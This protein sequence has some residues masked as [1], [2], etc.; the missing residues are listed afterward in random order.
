MDKLHWALDSLVLRDDTLFG[1]GWLFHEEKALR[2]LNLEI[3]FAGGD[4]ASRM[5]LEFDKPRDDVAAAYPACA[6]AQKPGYM[7]FGGFKA[8]AERMAGLALVGEWED[9]EAIGVDIPLASVTPIPVKYPRS[10][11]P[12]RAWDLLR[13]GKLRRLYGEYRAFR[14]YTSKDPADSPDSVPTLLR[15]RQNPIVLVVDH[16]LGGGANHYRE[17]WV[18]DKI[19]AGFDVLVLGFHVPTLTH[20]LKVQGQGV[21]LRY[22]IPGLDYLLRLLKK[23]RLAELVYNNAVSYLHPQQVP[24]LLAALKRRG[25]PQLTLLAHDFFMVCPSFFLL[26]QHGEFCGIPPIDACRR[27]LD[28]HRQGFVSLFPAKSIDQW[29]RAWAEAIGLADQIMVFSNSSLQLLLRA[30]PDINPSRVAVIPHQ[31]EQAPLTPV[32][33]SHTDSLRIGV[34][35][36]IAYHKGAQVVKALADE[37][38]RRQ[39]AIPIVVIGTIEA[40]CDP[41]VVRQTGAYQPGQLPR[42]IEEASANIMLFPSICAETFSYVVQELMEME[43]PIACFDRGAPAERLRAYPKGLILDT[44]D[45]APV[46]DAL[47]AFH[48]RIYLTR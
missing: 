36:N 8:P 26:D 27:C 20:V 21:D 25:N 2:S 44:L 43:L 14:H 22:D 39:L 32:T 18:A 48:N 1:Y 38:R 41:S 9:G 15:Q 28:G 40:A 17:Q 16:D 24:A 5:E 7:I 10:A 34:V 4:A 46:L 12:L 11:F 3:R 31:R 6:T 37:I 42:L 29:R 45:A 23:V 47:L 33:P 30:Y 35:G 13:Q 19:K